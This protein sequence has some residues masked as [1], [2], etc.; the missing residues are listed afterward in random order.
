[1]ICELSDPLGFERIHRKL[2]F[3][4]WCRFRIRRADAEDIAQNAV[5][6]YCEVRGRYQ[7]QANHHAIL[8]G[9][10]RK[11]CLEFIER[12]TREKEGRLRLQRL[13]SADNPGPMNTPDTLRGPALEPVVD[14]IIRRENGKKIQEALGELRPQARELFELLLEEGVG[15]KGLIDRYG[16]NKNTLDSRLRTARG[17]FRRILQSK[18]VM[19]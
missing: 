11:K 2:V 6:S 1:M 19:I 10:F 4:A 17:E 5:A 13:G 9:I 14:E 3:L 12:E 16:L 15:R 18:G 7:D 8:I